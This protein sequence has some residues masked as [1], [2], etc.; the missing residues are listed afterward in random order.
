MCSILLGLLS[1]CRQ[2]PASLWLCLA[3][4][5]GETLGFVYTGQIEAPRRGTAIRELAAHP[6][7]RF[8]ER[9]AAEVLPLL[10]ELTDREVHLLLAGASLTEGYTPYLYHRQMEAW[11]LGLASHLARYRFRRRLDQAYLLLL[12]SREHGT[13]C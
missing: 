2:L 3:F 11:A 4:N 9:L 6:L 8:A 7:Q 1:R 5:D 13:Y 12:R 10:R